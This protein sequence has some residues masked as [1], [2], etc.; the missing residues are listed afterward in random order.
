MKELL[1]KIAAWLKQ[2]WQKVK[3]WIYTDLD[4]DIDPDTMCPVEDL[5]AGSVA[6]AISDEAKNLGF[7]PIMLTLRNISPN[8][9]DLICET[10]LVP[11][12]DSLKTEMTFSLD[13]GETLTRQFYVNA[14]ADLLNFKK[15]VIIGDETYYA[16]KGCVPKQG[17]HVYV[18]IKAD[19]SISITKKSCEN[20]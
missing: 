14:N 3:D 19:G 9:V 15:A 13:I 16:N 10:K 4:P 12:S 7:Y 20:S 5:K 18:T 8:K 17:L 6:P 11:A 1:N 2:L